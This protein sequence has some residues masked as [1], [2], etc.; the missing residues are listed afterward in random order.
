MADEKTREELKAEADTLLA[1]RIKL[2]H[3]IKAAAELRY[4]ASNAGI[5]RK[6]FALCRAIEKEFGSETLRTFV[7][8]AE[9]VIQSEIDAGLLSEVENGNAL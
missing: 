3:K 4:R 8:E 2:Q 7:L 6:Y 9:A 5:G 1:E